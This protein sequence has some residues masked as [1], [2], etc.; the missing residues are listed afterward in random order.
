[1]DHRVDRP[2]GRPLGIDAAE[3][4]V[5]QND[6]L[7]SLQQ[8][9]DYIELDRPVRRLGVTMWGL[10]GEI[11]RAGAKTIYP[12]APNL[13]VFSRSVGVQ[14]RLMALKV[15]NHAGL[16]TSRAQELVLDYVNR[17]ID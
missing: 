4:F 2:D 6:G 11:G 13:P 15:D 3:R 14:R 7:I 5:S 9:P 1:L 16:L 17:F 8:L 12:I 10:G